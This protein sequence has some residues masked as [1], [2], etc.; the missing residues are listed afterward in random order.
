MGFSLSGLNPGAG[1]MSTAALQSPASIGVNP[2]AS[3]PSSILA[4][5]APSSSGGAGPLDSSQ[6]ANLLLP[7]LTIILQLLMTVLG[8]AA[9]NVFGGSLGSP[10]GG[11]NEEGG[12]T[13]AGG[14]NT[15]NP[16]RP[17]PQ[18]L[19]D[20]D[21]KYGDKI[22]KLV[23]EKNAKYGS[24]LTRQFVEAEIMQES[25]GDTMNNGDNGHSRGLLQLN[26]G[27]GGFQAAVGNGFKEPPVGDPSDPRYNPDFNLSIG[28]DE[29]AQYNAKYGGDL[30]HT[31][32]AYETG[33]SYYDDAYASSVLSHMNGN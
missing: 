21:R 25:S 11:G 9:G 18:N 12:G 22:Q 32:A 4:T 8:G 3:S 1:L 24:H 6:M 15:P 5:P 14:N 7:L 19:K 23:D 20:I 29:L 16:D 30:K 2:L 26:T 31:A 33:D 13:P 17:T 27:N 10:T 28:I